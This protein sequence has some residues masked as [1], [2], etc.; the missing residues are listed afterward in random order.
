MTTLSP[1][2]M[3]CWRCLGVMNGCIL[4]YCQN[5]FCHHCF[6]RHTKKC[7]YA[8]AQTRRMKRLD[9]PMTPPLP[10][11]P[12]D[13][14]Y[15]KGGSPAIPQNDDEDRLGGDV[16]EKPSH[17]TPPPTPQWL[18]DEHNR[19]ESFLAS[20]R[21]RLSWCVTWASVVAI[22]LIVALSLYPMP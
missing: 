11:N 10:P 14:L 19:L 12:A 18:I 3:S 5:A 7:V 9:I 21:K 4:C 2:C 16:R 6:V 17:P 13:P 20:E 8:I 1:P 15:K 22:A